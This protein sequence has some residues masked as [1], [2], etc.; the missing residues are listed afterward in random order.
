MIEYTINPISFN[1][2]TGKLDVDIIPHVDAG[3]SVQTYEIDLEESILAEIIAAPDTIAQKAILRKRIIRWYNGSIQHNWE[4]ERAFNTGAIP[5]ALL[6]LI[7][8]PG[9]TPVS[10]VEVEALLA[11]D[12]TGVAPTPVGT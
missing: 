12:F 7:G 10:A 2:V 8:V 1:T 4:I 3:V 11:H 6:A 5:P 9:T